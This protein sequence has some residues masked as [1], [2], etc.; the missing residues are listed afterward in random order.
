MTSDRLLET[1]KPW[2]SG[3]KCQ[4]LTMDH[5]YKAEFIKSLFSYEM[6]HELMHDLPQSSYSTEIDTISKTTGFVF[7]II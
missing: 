2:L 4:L 1:E 3:Q 6:Y 7:A 5:I